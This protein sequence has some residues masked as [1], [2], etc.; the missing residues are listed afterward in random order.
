MA[1]NIKN[2]PSISVTYAS[3]GVSNN[4]NKFGMRPMQE[5]AF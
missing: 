3:S 1:E 5:R 4:I 2:I